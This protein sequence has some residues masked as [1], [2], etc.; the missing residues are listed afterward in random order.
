MSRFG[1]SNTTNYVSYSLWET[2]FVTDNIAFIR[3]IFRCQNKNIKI[4]EKF[5]LCSTLFSDKK[6]LICVLNALA[7]C[8]K[9]K[10]IYIAFFI[11][12]GPEHQRNL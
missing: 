10:N 12:L 4:T 5:I 2:F 1:P 6:I 9:I 7:Y 3:V 8:C 11:G